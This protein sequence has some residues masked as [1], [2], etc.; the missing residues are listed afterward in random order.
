MATR[1]VIDGGDSGMRGVRAPPARELASV[2]KET[3]VPIGSN[4]DILTARETGRTMAH[5]ACLTGTNLTLVA[6]AISELARNILLYARKGEVILGI[7]ERNGNVGI[8]VVARDDGP[9]I[10]DVQRAMQ[11][12]FSTSGSLGLG[13]PGVRR[14]MDEF[15]IVSKVGEGTIVTARKWKH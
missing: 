3:R 11:V 12:G 8:A 14:L 6:T 1:Y 7:V 15:E 4:K 10:L 2:K 9:G 5:H 13:L